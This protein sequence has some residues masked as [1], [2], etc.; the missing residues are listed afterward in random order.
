MLS[1]PSRIASNRLLPTLI[2]DNHPA[3]IRFPHGWDSRVGPIFDWH[4][5]LACTKFV[6]LQYRK[7]HGTVFEHEFLCAKLT[8]GSFCVFERFGDPN[9]RVDA[10]IEQGSLA[11]DVAEII[12]VDHFAIIDTTS[13]VLQEI[14]LSREL[15]VL[16]IFEICYYIQ[17]NRRTR[18][19]TLQRYNCYFFCWCVLS[20]LARR[21]APIFR[22]M[23][24]ESKSDKYAGRG[25]G[26]SR[27]LVKRAMM[28]MEVGI[29]VLIDNADNG[30]NNGW[31]DDWEGDSDGDGDD[32]DY[33]N[34]GGGRGG[35]GGSGDRNVDGGG[36]RG[37]DLGV[38]G[39]VD[40][41][42]SIAIEGAMVVGD[43]FTR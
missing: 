39:V 2:K 16:D 28:V 8:D 34:G 17:Q 15:D 10:L 29:G 6:S 38:G 23:Y 42:D 32:E 7:E 26:T 33:G 20:V 14:A 22:V 18:T 24:P 27:R 3:A 36:D 21:F 1:V 31:V 5:K 25:A 19:Y 35:G 43:F 9:A 40:S 12:S 30:S 11:H 13:F 41:T 37:G 4:K